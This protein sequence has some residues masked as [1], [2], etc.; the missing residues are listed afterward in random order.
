MNIVQNDWCTI[1][2]ISDGQFHWPSPPEMGDSV[3]EGWFDDASGRTRR[4]NDERKD[5]YE[6]D[7]TTLYNLV[8][9]W[10]RSPR[11]NDS[12]VNRGTDR[13]LTTDCDTIAVDRGMWEQ[14]LDR[15]EVCLYFM[16]TDLFLFFFLFFFFFRYTTTGSRTFE[17]NCPSRSC[18]RSIRYA[19]SISYF[20]SFFFFSFF[21][22][23]TKL[24]KSYEIRWA[25][26]PVM[27]RN[28]VTD[29]SI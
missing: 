23:V 3:D 4:S 25:I 24:T 11:R 13:F 22:T 6:Y 10:P 27:Y 26:I 29:V 14:D 9:A 16:N 8:S 15:K 28:Y 21:F 17:G 19:H 2:W 5:T 20:H 7:N 18:P 1:S 12:S